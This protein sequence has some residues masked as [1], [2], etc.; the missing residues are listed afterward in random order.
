VLDTGAPIVLGREYASGLCVA[1]FGSLPLATSVCLVQI[2]ASLALTVTCCFPAVNLEIGASDVQEGDN[3][4]F[5]P[6]DLEDTCSVEE[7]DWSITF[8]SRGDDKTIEVG[9]VGKP[10]ILEVIGH[11]PV[12]GAEEL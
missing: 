5:A 11:R 10:L 9:D 12:F 1:N 3:H 8:L 7:D 2:A 4:V 6:V